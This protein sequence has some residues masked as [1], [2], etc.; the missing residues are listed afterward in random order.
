M[1]QKRVYYIDCLRV[2]AALLV[3]AVHCNYTAAIPSNKIWT[4]ILGVVGSPSSELFLTISGALLIPVKT[5]EKEFYKKRFAKLLPPF[6]FWSLFGVFFSVFVKGVSASKVP[7]MLFCI[8]FKTWAVGPFWFVYVISGMYLIAPILTPWINSASPKKIRFY[9]Y[10]WGI[11]LL[12]PYTNFIYDN[13]WPIEDNSTTFTSPL[14][15][16]S[17]YVGYM[18]LGFYLRKYDLPIKKSIYHLVIFILTLIPLIIIGLKANQFRYIVMDNL[19]ILSAIQV[20]TIFSCFKIWFA[21]DMIITRICKYLTNYTFGVYLIH[22]FMIWGVYQLLGGKE[23]FPAYFELPLACV[24]AFTLSLIFVI[25][26]SKIK[27]VSILV[28]CK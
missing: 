4:Q 23:V 12:L 7:F 25:V 28:G 17:G 20:I 1:N 8:P 22:T 21:K 13:F 19:Q 14:Y 26:C 2:F 3:V 24:L 5:S 15:M 11:S 27:F 6:L 16:F 18:I 10:L 9:L